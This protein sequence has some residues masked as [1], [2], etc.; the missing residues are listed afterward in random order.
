MIDATNGRDFFFGGGG[1]T[2]AE[3]ALQT[4]AEAPLT[5]LLNTL[6]TVLFDTFTH[7][8]ESEH[9]AFGAAVTN[10]SATNV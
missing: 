6:T 9:A 10:H 5:A 4:D 8:P 1:E 2:S 7:I 3:A